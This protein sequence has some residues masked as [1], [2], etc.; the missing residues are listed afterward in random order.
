MYVITQCYRLVDSPCRSRLLTY[1]TQQSAGWGLPTTLDNVCVWLIEVHVHYQSA[2][3]QVF[4]KWWGTIK[5]TDLY[6][7]IWLVITSYIIQR[8][9]CF[10]YL[11]F[12]CLSVL[13][14]INVWIYLCD[15]W[16]VRPRDVMQ[17]GRQ[18]FL[19]LTQV[20]ESLNTQSAD[21]SGSSTQV[22]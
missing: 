10:P 7:N 11:H 2:A 9:Y 15:M 19:L 14:Y 4:S 20:S 13:L 5:N 17:C 6:G 16:D 21:L 8:S 22:T 1:L 18:T 3:I 12:N